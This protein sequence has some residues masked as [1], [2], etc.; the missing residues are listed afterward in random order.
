MI[1][2]TPSSANVIALDRS[3][4]M[5]Q[6]ALAESTSCKP[7]CADAEQLPLRHQSVDLIFAN[8]LLPWQE[9]IQSLLRE[10][11]RVLR[12]DGLLM[13]TAFGPD[14]MQE[15]K[16]WEPST[17]I[18]Y[19]MDMHDVGDSLLKEGFADPVLD[20]NY[21]TLTYRNKKKLITELMH[22]GMLAELEEAYHLEQ[23]M[24]EA[25]EGVWSIT[26]EMIY[27]HAFAPTAKEQVAAT[28]GVVKIP[29][30]QLR[31]QLISKSS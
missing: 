21:Y 2:Q 13:L 11:R 20:V 8:F 16:A 23:K 25:E 10:W 30:S 3:Q 28:D 5:L 14:T 26:Y 1:D 12:P 18:P 17:T 9:D 29:L 27:A 24:T 7:L 6:Y 31:Q 19:C 4:S 15:C 22:S